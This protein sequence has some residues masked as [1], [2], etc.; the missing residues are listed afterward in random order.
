MI[1]E[2]Y[3][4]LNNLAEH[5]FIFEKLLF[6]SDYWKL[7]IIFYDDKYIVLQYILRYQ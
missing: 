1:V 6:N 4:K 3:K 2:D 7:V 5:F